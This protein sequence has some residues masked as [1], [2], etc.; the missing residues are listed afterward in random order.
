MRS[1][2]EIS[3]S[4]NPSKP[5]PYCARQTCADA[6][7]E[8]LVRGDQPGFAACLDRSLE[9]RRRVMPVDPRVLRMAEVAR[10]VGASVNSAG[11]GGAVVG[12]VPG[13]WARL[14]AALR[15]EGAGCVQLLRG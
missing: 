3:S 8:A 7:R 10:S 9:L 13:D 2:G 15:A 4:G 12:T 1:P 11:S 5:N 14:A 6:A